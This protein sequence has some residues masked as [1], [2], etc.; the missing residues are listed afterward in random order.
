MLGGS[1]LPAHTARI[2]PVYTPQAARGRGFAQKLVAL[3]CQYL[4]VKEPTTVFLFTDAQIPASNICYQRV[5]FEFI[6]DHLHVSL[7]A[8]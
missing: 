8:S 2:G 4:Q 5:G 6:A 7:L 1:L 3:T